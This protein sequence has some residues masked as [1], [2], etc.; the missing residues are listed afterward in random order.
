VSVHQDAS[1]G[2]LCT[3]RKSIDTIE[4]KEMSGG[5]TDRGDPDNFRTIDS[6]M[7]SP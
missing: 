1:S 6:E 3:F 7:L 5:S 4:L 2:K